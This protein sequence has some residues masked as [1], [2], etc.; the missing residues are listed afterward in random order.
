MYPSLRETGSDLYSSSITS[1]RFYNS[2]TPWSVLYTFQR[3]AM[4]GTKS[5]NSKREVMQRR[6]CLSPASRWFLSWHRLTPTHRDGGDTFLTYIGGL[7]P[8]CTA[9]QP[10]SHSPSLPSSDTLLTAIILE[11]TFIDFCNIIYRPVFL[12]IN[13]VSETGLC[14]H[15]QV[16]ILLSW[17]HSMDRILSPDNRINTRQ[18]IYTKA[19]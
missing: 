14:F 10:I 16:K 1:T 9:S 8:S 19:T 7:S 12:F 5:H 3:A 13:N 6:D 2:W 17:A 11:H 15:P 18:D 4:P